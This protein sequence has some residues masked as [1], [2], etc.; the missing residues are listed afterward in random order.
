MNGEIKPD[1]TT[2]AEIYDTVMEDVDYEVWADFIDEII[3]VHHPDPQTVL[4]LACGT[5]SL[6]FALHRYGCYD[7]MGTDKS[8]AMVEK[9]RAKAKNKKVNI[10]FEQ[11][12][13]LNIG[14]DE[15]FDIIVSIFDSVNYLHDPAD[16]KKLLQQTKKLMDPHSLFIFDFTTPKNSRQA[17]QYLD[18]EEGITPDNYKFFRKSKYDEKQQ[19]HYNIFEIEKLTED[20][21][22]VIARYTEE[23]QQRTY[24]LTQMQQIVGETDF[25]IVANYS[26]FDLDEATPESLRITM[27]LRC[28]NTPS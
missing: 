25:E 28:P 23:H 8:Q 16:I 22:K 19:I 4:E 20:R 26:E 14:L 7:I 3:Q 2:L 17:I 13:F 6:A 5:G 11:M 1:Y 18:N 9:A 12:D 24:S 10:Q 21:R 27:V 15:T